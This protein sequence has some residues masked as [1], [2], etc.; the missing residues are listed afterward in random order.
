LCSIIGYIGS[1]DGA[2]L[3][4]KALER[5]E[6]RGYDSAGVAML[7]DG[8]I[9]MK[10]GVG[11]VEEVNA[12]QQLEQLPGKVGIGHTRWAT[13][14][15]VTAVNAHPH[16]SWSGKIAIVHNGIIENYEEL[17]AEVGRRGY[18]FRSETD[19]EVIANL[20]QCN[21]DLGMTVEESVTETLRELKG[22]YAFVALM[23]D[24][25]L[26]GAR[27]HAPLIL[28][29]GKNGAFVSSDIIGFVQE[30]DDVI[31]LDNGQFVV[32]SHEKIRISDFNGAPV[33]QRV[34]RVSKEL[35]DSNKGIY[36]HY[37]LKEINQQPEVIVAA[38]R[39]ARAELEIL[40]GMIK[41]AEVVYI[42]GSG[43]SY[44]AAL[45]GKHLFS[46]HAGIRVEPIISSEAQFSPMYLDSRSL[47]LAISQS[48]ESADVIEAASIAKEHGAAVASIVNVQTSSLAR[49]SSISVGINCGPEIGVAATKSFTSQL[50]VLYAL[51]D[52]LCGGSEYDLQSA[53]A[54]MTEILADDE[55]IRKLAEE[56]KD[57]TDLYVL[58]DGVHYIIACEAAL[59]LKEL[60]YVHAE[61]MPSG[62]L[63][64]GPL[65]LLDPTSY[66]L[67]FNPYD[68]TYANTLASAHEAKARGVKIIGVSD[69][70]NEIYDH[71]IRIPRVEEQLFSILEILPIQLLA[72]HMAV[73]R[74]AN[75]DYPRNLAKSVTVR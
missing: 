5:M 15:G 9:L 56:L 59:K 74:N 35:A 6:Y 31:Y 60:A 61:A 41:Q 27:N 12:A 72:Y 16:L 8:A 20:L 55:P 75:P 66:I 46:Q 34:V 37:T 21:R 71:W 19:S 29:I 38:A 68:S 51:N 23:D 13:H 26:V 69:R 73:Q 33:A 25:S 4:V 18:L 42:T 52:M 63:K 58:G 24:G 70:P 3:L 57:I 43:S 39:S 22:K 40:A 44:N 53:P 54:A 2:P 1:R 30:A 32:I 14:G 10:K 36:V 11:R 28:G 50:A 62:E 47:L 49:L 17:K 65:A 48:G 45:V 64:H 67:V 7:A